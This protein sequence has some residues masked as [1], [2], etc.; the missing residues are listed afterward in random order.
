MG[1][2]SEPPRRR[3]TELLALSHGYD[4]ENHVALLRSVDQ[5]QSWTIKTLLPWGVYALAAVGDDLLIVGS[6][7]NIL[8]MR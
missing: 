5:G 1:A 6:E 8:R 7:S 4:R 3:G 2:G